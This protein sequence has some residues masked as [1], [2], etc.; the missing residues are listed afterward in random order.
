MPDL[1]NAGLPST[2]FRQFSINTSKHLYRKCKNLSFQKHL[3]LNYLPLKRLYEEGS[4]N[5][6]DSYV[7]P[8]VI[9]APG[10]WAQSYLPV[11]LPKHQA[12][13]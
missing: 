8:E 6:H 4:K 11:K 9:L 13:G 12:G 10:L 1:G 3:Q 7:P 5:N 2:F